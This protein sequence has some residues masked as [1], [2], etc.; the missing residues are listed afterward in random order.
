WSGSIA[1]GGRLQVSI[2]SGSATISG[3]VSG[4]DGGGLTVTGSLTLSGFD[5]YNSSTFVNLGL[6]RVSGFLGNSTVILGLVASATLDGGPQTVLG[7]VESIFAPNDVV[8]GDG[9]T[10]SDLIQFGPFSFFDVTLGPSSPSSALIVL[11][12]EVQLGGK[13]QLTLAPGFTPA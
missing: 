8:I 1:L 10:V 12:R 3:D 5:T 2:P 13:L 7:G 4:V 11:G 9:E 6:L